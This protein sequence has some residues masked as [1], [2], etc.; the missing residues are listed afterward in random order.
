MHLKYLHY[1]GNEAS[2]SLL[3]AYGI[4]AKDTQIVDTLRSKQYPNC[5]ESNR[6]DAKFCAKCRMV[7]T[8]DAYIE[9]L[10]NQKEK[11]DKIVAIEKTLELQSSQLRAL[12]TA[13]GNIKDQN[14]A[15]NVARTL[16]DSGILIEAKR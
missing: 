8:Y 4:I 10:D 6:P 11:D 7:L 1:Y 9:T 14:H 2:E 13:V 16:Y 12:I 3:E 15:N 5:S